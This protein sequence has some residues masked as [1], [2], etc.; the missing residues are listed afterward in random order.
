MWL[1]SRNY[2][3][4]MRSHTFGLITGNTDGFVHLNGILT[5]SVETRLERRDEHTGG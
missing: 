5:S 3:A 2:F 4:F 1:R